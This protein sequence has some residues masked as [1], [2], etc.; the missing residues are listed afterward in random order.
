MKAVLFVCENPECLFVRAVRAIGRRT[1]HSKHSSPPT[2]I[3]WDKTTGCGTV[4][5]SIEYGETNTKSELE[6]ESEVSV[7]AFTKTS[8]LS[9]P[10]LST[11]NS[12]EVERGSRI[13]KHFKLG[14][15]ESVYSYCTR[16][17]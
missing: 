1:K 17:E 12:V 5:E 4:H 7:Y 3:G 10:G 14:N 8:A 11:R 6:S 13:Q 2:S 15:S 9:L 16:R